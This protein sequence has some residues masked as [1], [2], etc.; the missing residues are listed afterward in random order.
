MMPSIRD[1]A[2]AAQVSPATVSQI[3]NDRGGLFRPETRERVKRIAKQLDY[4]PSPLGRAVNGKQSMSLGILASSITTPV[5][6]EGFNQIEQH[7]RRAGYTCYLAGWSTGSPKDQCD[8][9][10]DLVDRRVDGLFVHFESDLPEQ[11]MQMLT[12]IPIPVVFLYHAPHDGVWAVTVDPAPA[13]AQLAGHLAEL[14]H[15]HVTVMT[16]SFHRDRPHLRLEA[17]IDALQSHAI[18]VEQRF[19][20]KLDLDGVSDQFAADLARQGLAGTALLANNDYYAIA[21]I[22]A[23]R[24]HG[25]RVPEDISVVGYDD[26]PVA[27]VCDP[28]LTTIANPTQTMAVGAFGLMQS[29]ISGQTEPRQIKLPKTLTLRESTAPVASP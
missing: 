11:A 16:G 3:L 4:R 8:V 25:L 6:V 23:L 27:A 18:R 29:A 13:Y 2:K 17:C 1:V 5:F 9:I 26:V 12:K 20:A 22:H 14:G 24:S 7:A 10:A 15:R 28:P 21:M 19:Q